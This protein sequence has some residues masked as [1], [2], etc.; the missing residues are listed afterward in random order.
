GYNE[1][2]K[3]IILAN[4]SSERHYLFWQYV[5]GTLEPLQSSFDVNQLDTWIIRLLAQAKQVR[6]DQVLQLLLNTFGGYLANRDHPG[7]RNEIEQRL[8]ALMAD[9]IKAPPCGRGTGPC[10]VDTPRPGL[11]RI[12]P[13][14]SFG[15]AACRSHSN[16]WTAGHFRRAL[17]GTSAGAPRVG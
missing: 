6:K 10:A 11:R 8:R 14:L 4:D 17:N 7:W 2:G 12:L 13:L 16:G 15:Y 3:A 1:Q 5:R 9:M